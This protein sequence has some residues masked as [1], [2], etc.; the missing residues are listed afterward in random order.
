MSSGAGENWRSRWRK[1]AL[2]EGLRETKAFL[3]QRTYE[4]ASAIAEQR[5]ERLPVTLGR[6]IERA[7]ASV[8]HH[9]P[10]LVARPAPTPTLP[11]DIVELTRTIL[12]S[13]F[14]GDTGSSRFR[15]LA[16]VHLLVSEAMRGHRPTAT[17][18]AM[19]AGSHKSQLDLL[20]K[21]LLDRGVIVKTHAP[22][23]KGAPTAK[24]LGLSPNAIDALQAAHEAAT[25]SAIIP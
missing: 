6:L 16:F 1:D 17:S 20:A 18:L 5:S 24:A 25:G 9:K 19:V 4:R 13:R 14:P 21:I 2:R 15:Q 12:A 22:G 7:V 23:L 8:E 10:K 3:D 11:V